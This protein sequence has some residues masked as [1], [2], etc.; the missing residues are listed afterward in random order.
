MNYE[1]S[2]IIYENKHLP[3]IHSQEEFRIKI[4]E[5][6]KLSENH[7]SINDL[8]K[9]IRSK[10][11]FQKEQNVTYAGEIDFIGTDLYFINT[12]VWEYIWDKKLMIDF[13]NYSNNR[14]SNVYLLKNNQY[15]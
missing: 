8:V 12:V 9:R 11:L 7:F 2:K 14:D 5:E 6:I 3:L 13:V 1:L 15:E 10:C 4:L